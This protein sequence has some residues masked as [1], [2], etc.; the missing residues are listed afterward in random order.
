MTAN[1]PSAAP[2]ASRRV[3]AVPAVVIA[4]SW[5]VPEAV[6]GDDVNGVMSNRVADALPACCKPRGCACRDSRAA[7]FIPFASGDSA[8]RGFIRITGRRIAS[9]PRKVSA[10]RVWR[11][12]RPV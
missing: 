9:A 7:E 11:M 6:H 4:S 2:M 12:L 10:G 1:R 5:S 3:L 8:C